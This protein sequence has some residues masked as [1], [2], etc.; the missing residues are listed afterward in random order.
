MP[1]TNI[2]RSHVVSALTTMHAEMA[3]QI[4]HHERE[5]RRISIDQSHVAATLKLLEPAIDL[6][7]I[8][9]KPHQER[10][11]IFRPGEAP[12]AILDVLRVAAG[13]LTSREMV[14]RILADRNIEATAERID[15]VQKSLL[16]AIKG[17]EAKKLVRVVATG[18]GGTRSWAIA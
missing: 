7:T 15:S 9:A 17:L 11:V 6:R 2:N 16:T 10:S 8:R 18:K 14:E 5:A 3:G 13:P 12:R 4:Q 1:E